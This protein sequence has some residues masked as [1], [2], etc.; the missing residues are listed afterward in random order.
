MTANS[1]MYPLS[2]LL[3]KNSSYSLSG[4]TGRT[5]SI[6]LFAK[7]F[8]HSSF[9][10]LLLSLILFFSQLPC[11]L[12]FLSRQPFHHSERFVLMVFH[13]LP[14]AEKVAFK[15][16]FPRNIHSSELPMQITQLLTNISLRHQNT[17]CM[18]NRDIKQSFSI[19]LP[20][21]QFYKLPL[22][23]LKS[24][25]ETTRSFCLKVHKSE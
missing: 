9:L 23:W 3:L 14:R 20:F 8:L 13:H 19:K 2:L 21:L 4:R 1:N 11:C 16:L 5:G 7:H 18:L 6:V 15:F 17:L 22:L 24:I 10:L 25:E 12:F